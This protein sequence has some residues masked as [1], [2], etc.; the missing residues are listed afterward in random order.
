MNSI[1]I[2]GQTGPVS[3]SNSLAFKEKGSSPASGPGFGQVFSSV[4][5]R[6]ET[7]STPAEGP[8]LGSGADT[9]QDL[10]EKMMDPAI[11]GI[12]LSGQSPL[13]AVTLGPGMNAITPSTV[14]PDMASLADFA[15]AQGLDEHAVRWLF[16]GAQGGLQGKTGTAAG[17]AVTDTAVLPGMLLAGQTTATT[18]GQISTGETL[19]AAGSANATAIQGLAASGQPS[20]LLAQGA[21][22]AGADSATQ[23]QPA[24]PATASAAL[25]LGAVAGLDQATSRTP[26]AAPSATE[27]ARSPEPTESLMLHLRMVSPPLWM[28]RAN[29]AAPPPGAPTSQATGTDG[30][31]A[32]LD[33]LLAD[34]DATSPTDIHTVELDLTSLLRDLRTSSGPSTA[35]MLAALNQGRADADAALPADTQD[36]DLQI[37]GSDAMTRPMETPA[38]RI[39]TTEP[40]A[41]RAPVTSANPAA[42]AEQ[43]QQ[44]A[45]KMGQA[46]GQRMLSEIEKGHWEMKMMLRPATLGHIEVQMSMRGGELDA[47]FHAPQAMTRE[48][49]QDGLSRLRETL[50]QAGM[51]VANI[52]V[53]DNSSQ[54]R[55]GESTPGQA[56]ASSAT[57][58]SEPQEQTQEPVT[59]RPMSR[60]SDGWDVMV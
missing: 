23:E 41:A 17:I 43:L 12:W 34:S 22:S 31:Q 1:E 19:A 27:T 51:D 5:A 24:L 21:S 16:Q 42:R 29:G 7:A 47:S 59:A 18:A 14:G 20:T 44:Q 2:S 33:A 58:S 15:R 8:P 3:E 55:G 30:L 39:T 13:K 35:V 32:D 26:L 10:A 4:V 49:L 28:Q 38:H 56:Q 6:D 48:L 60:R 50:T 54:K 40:L 57:G 53:G 11:A 52:H 46:I 9:G 45:E 37:E 25:M 36:A